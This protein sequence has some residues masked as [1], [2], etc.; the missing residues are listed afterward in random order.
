MPAVRFETNILQAANHSLR[1]A[2]RKSP[3][4]VKDQA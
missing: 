2:K 4:S 1:G 3:A